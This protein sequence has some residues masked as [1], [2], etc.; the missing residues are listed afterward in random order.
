MVSKAISTPYDAITYKIIG[1][2]MAVHRELGP[3]LRENMYQRALE[4]NSMT[5]CCWMNDQLVGMYNPV[6]EQ[7]I[8]KAA[9]FNPHLHISR[10]P[11][12]S[13]TVSMDELVLLPAPLVHSAAG[14]IQLEV[15]CGAPP[16]GIV[17]WWTGDGALDN[18]VYPGRGEGEG[19]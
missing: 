10:P 11:Q 9:V 17:G 5:F 6:S 4:I 1:C 14:V 19:A 16:E 2:A 3:G 12:A 15:S 13:M 7:D 8:L 18:L